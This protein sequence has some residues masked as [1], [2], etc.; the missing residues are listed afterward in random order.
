[1][2]HFTCIT[3]FFCFCVYLTAWNWPWSQSIDFTFVNIKLLLEHL[4]PV[5]S[6]YCPA[7]NQNIFQEAGCH[8]LVFVTWA[9]TSKI[10]FSYANQIRITTACLRPNCILVVRSKRGHYCLLP[11]NNTTISA[12]TD[13]NLFFFLVKFQWDY[14]HLTYIIF[15]I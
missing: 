12:T 5:M 2:Y 9:R 3:C 8:Q 13:I 15:L 10:T 14:F 11:K 6:S 7:F 1:M 4:K